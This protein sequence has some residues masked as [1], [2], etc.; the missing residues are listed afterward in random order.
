[1]NKFEFKQEDTTTGFMDS[2]DNNQRL[3]E[4]HWGINTFASF[5]FNYSF[6]TIF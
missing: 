2:L 1:M 5:E 3:C 4:L 6:W